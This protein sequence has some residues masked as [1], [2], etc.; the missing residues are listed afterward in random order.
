MC[1]YSAKI[2]AYSFLFW[3]YLCLVLELGCCW[4]HLMSLGVFLFLLEK[5][6]EDAYKFL[7]VCLV[8]FTCEALWSWT[9]IC[10][11]CFYDTSDWSVQL[12]YFFLIKF[13]K[14]VMSLESCPFL[15]GCQI[16][17]HAIVHSILSLFLYSCSICCDFSLLN[18]YFV[19]VGFFSPFLGEPALGFIEFFSIVFSVYVLFY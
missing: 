8:E 11:E 14:A 1:L 9:F 10:S 5:F 13:W 19:Y 3:W 18:S 17:W 15:R 6:K 7:F 2:L 4:C 16:F 12:N